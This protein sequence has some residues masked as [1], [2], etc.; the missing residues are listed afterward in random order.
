MTDKEFLEGETE[1]PCYGQRINTY[2]LSGAGTVLL[3]LTELLLTDLSIGGILDG[4]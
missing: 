4:R 3:E 1:C 2:P